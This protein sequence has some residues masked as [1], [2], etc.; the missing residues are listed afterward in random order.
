MLESLLVPLLEKAFADMIGK[1]GGTDSGL[2]NLL[3]G[4]KSEAPKKEKKKRQSKKATN[5]LVDRRGDPTPSNVVI[6]FPRK[7]TALKISVECSPL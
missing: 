7:V 3:S 5:T 4:V 2:M 6:V 1:F